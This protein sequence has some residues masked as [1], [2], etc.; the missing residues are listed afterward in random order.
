MRPDPHTDTVRCVRQ[1]LPTPLDDVDPY[2]A[3]VAAERPTPTDRPWVMVNMVASTDGA[4]AV[5]GVSGGLGG[6]A[7]KAVFSAIRSLAD[8]V[9]AAA[10]TTRAESY[11]P[12]RMSAER[13]ADRAARGQAPVPRLAVVS[14]SLD[15][16]PTATMFTEVQQPT[17]VFTGRDP[18]PERLASLADVA[19]VVECAGES[20][21]AEEIAGHLHGIGA[22]TVLVEGG[23]SLNGVFAG[24]GMIDEF[25]LT[26]S[27]A[28]V[29]GPS[30]RLVRGAPE[31]VQP[32]RL[33]HLWEADGVLLARYV[34]A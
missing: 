29:G 11:G 23:P 3:H 19:T 14:R 8:V 1:L 28:L 22:R 13:R 21:S 25:D 26:T 4:T 15:L 9:V 20:V 18:D 27:A 31:Q 2:L 7:D 6:V 33:A 34:R 16:D 17:I 5:D 12:P 10:G 32:M 24:A 30:P